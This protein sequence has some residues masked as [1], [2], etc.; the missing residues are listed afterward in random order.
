MHKPVPVKR[1]FHHVRLAGL[2]EVAIDNTG[3]GGVED[4]REGWQMSPFKGDHERLEVIR[5]RTRILGEDVYPFKSVM[6]VG[7]G[8]G[9][10]WMG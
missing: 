1:K 2:A 6:G 8:V 9:V 7:V 10:E 3:E 5:R 4:G